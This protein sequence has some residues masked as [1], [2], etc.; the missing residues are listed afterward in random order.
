VD[1][2]DVAFRNWLRNH[3][4]D[5]QRYEFVKRRGAAVA[6]GNP[7]IYK[8]MKTSVMADILERAKSG[9]Q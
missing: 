8:R 1:E 3:T 4:A 2:N 9:Q 6:N 7:D 5:R